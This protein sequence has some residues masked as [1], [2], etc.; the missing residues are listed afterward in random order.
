MKSKD[1]NKKKMKNQYQK[2]KRLLKNK[3]FN[4]LKLNY[5]KMKKNQLRKNQ[6]IRINM[7]KRERKERQES[8]I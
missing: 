8:Y 7:K 5:Y 6:K 4:K 2:N 1:Y 3:K